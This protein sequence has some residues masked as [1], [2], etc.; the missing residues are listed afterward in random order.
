M[1]PMSNLKI[2]QG[3]FESPSHQTRNAY[4]IAGI[5][6]GIENLVTP[7]TARVEYVS[8]SSLVLISNV[9][10]V[11]LPNGNVYNPYSL[12]AYFF[13]DNSVSDRSVGEI[14]PQGTV[15]YQEGTLG[16]A[17]GNHVHMQ[18]A[19]SPYQGGYPLIEISSGVWDLKGTKANIEDFYF[20]NSST[21]VIDDG[22]YTFKLVEDDPTDPIDPTDPLV[23]IKTKHYRFLI[24]KRKSQ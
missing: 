2:T 5:D 23:D 16:N 19:L 20:I 10:Q 24:F 14:I 11:K 3:R 1:I 6:T 13:H 7:F 21:N 15:F 18:M 9:D 17:T 8:S 12:Q 4:D 22:G